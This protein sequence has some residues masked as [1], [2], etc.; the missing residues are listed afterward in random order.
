MLKASLADKMNTLPEPPTDPDDYSL[1]GQEFVEMLV[2]RRS[3]SL[4]LFANLP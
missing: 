4:S 1:W 2:S 3:V